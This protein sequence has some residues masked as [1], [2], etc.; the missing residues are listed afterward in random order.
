MPVSAALDVMDRSLMKTIHFCNLPLRHPLGEKIA[1]FANL[2]FCDLRAKAICY[3]KRVAG[4][5]NIFL[6]ANPFKIIKTIIRLDPILVI[7]N[8][9]IRARA[10]KRFQ[11]QTMRCALVPDFVAEQDHFQVPDN[12]RLRL[13]NPSGFRT[14]ITLDTHN[15]SPIANGII[16]KISDC[17]P[18]FIHVC[19]S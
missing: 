11:N 6:R 9:S 8:K 18:S 14:R 4:M 3:A 7:S 12:H 19:I 10:A 13:K 15:S 5:N 2:F 17:Q 1:Y 16:W